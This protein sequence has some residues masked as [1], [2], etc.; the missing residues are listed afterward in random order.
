MQTV[1]P[2]AA[3]EWH[4]FLPA[5]QEQWLKHRGRVC[6]GEPP[7]V[8]RE[9]KSIDPAQL[10]AGHLKAIAS[11][12][13]RTAFEEVFRHFAP[14]VKAYLSK[15]GGDPG[16]AE[17]LMQETMA[18][19][20]RKAAQFDPAKA[21]ASTWIFTIARNLRIDAYRRER[22][23]EVDFDDPALVPEDEAPADNIIEARQNAE[24]MHEALSTLSQAEQDVLK[25]AFFEDKSQSVIATQLGIPL[26]TVKS[27]MRLSFGKLR[28]AMS[29]MLGDD[30]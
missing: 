16:L 28:V 4:P 26:G 25:L 13:D 10:M 14:R 6:V 21:S 29:E 18:A 1:V 3:K 2:L 5:L 7:T 8:T 30:K 19:V 17:E 15:S 11:S 24:M 9:L 12:Q 23:P 20:W 27:R 22:R